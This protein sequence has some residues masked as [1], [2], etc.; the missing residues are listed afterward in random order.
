MYR[1]L[2]E[3]P[4]KVIVGTTIYVVYVVIHQVW[5]WIVWLHILVVSPRVSVET[6]A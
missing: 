2:I 3:N 5:R 1:K 6:L 4:G